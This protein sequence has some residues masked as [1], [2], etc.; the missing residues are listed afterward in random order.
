MTV[1]VV[2]AG[3]AGLNAARA[4]AGL[5]REVVLVDAAPSVGGQYWRQRFSSPRTLPGVTHLASTVVWA[6]EGRRVHLLTGPAD[7]PGRSARTI[8]A[9]ALVIATGAY[10]RVV[11]FPGWDSAE[12]FTAGAAQ[13]L[14]KGQGVAVG[15]RVL[16]GGTG[17]FLLAVARSLLGVG[18]SVVGIAEANRP[19]R[20]DLRTGWGKVP[21]LLGYAPMLA[22]VPLWTRTA[23]VGVSGGVATV[24]RLDGAWNVVGTRSVEVDAVC[25]GYGFLPQLDVALAAGCEVVDGFVGVDSSQRTSVAGVF[26]CGEVTGVGGAD[27]A[28]VEGWVA[29]VAAGGGV[30]SRA[31]LRRV[32]AGRRFAAALARAFPVREGWRGWGSESTLVCRCEGVS[33]GEVLGAVR[34]GAVGARSLKLVSRVGLGRC[35]G[36]MCLSNVASLTG[37]E[38]DGRRPVVVPVRLGEIADG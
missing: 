15:Q 21:E 12:V 13:A 17:P 9:S 16:V 37:V 22:R 30:V 32:R 10:D 36:R 34:E 3:P 14:A 18:A 2:G 19:L 29:G 25:V 5:G 23:V 4:A 28:A 31:L 1:V 8:E 38:F 35:Q 33:V 26:A 27:L 7:G 11:P 6:V 20:W 24:A